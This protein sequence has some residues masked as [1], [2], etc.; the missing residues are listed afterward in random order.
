MICKECEHCNYV[1]MDGYMCD[2]INA[3][4]PEELVDEDIDCMI[5]DMISIYNVVVLDSD[6]CKNVGVAT[7][8][9]QL[10]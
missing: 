10:F 7:V 6:N 4:I 2:N 5:Y 8:K 9:Y 1:E 3:F